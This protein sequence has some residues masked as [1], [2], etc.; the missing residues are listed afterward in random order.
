MNNNNKKDN[1]TKYGEFVSS[2]FSWV[3]PTE[4]KNRAKEL[5]DMTKK[6]VKDNNNK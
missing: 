1:T 5:E 4:Q 3:T 2:F 6:K